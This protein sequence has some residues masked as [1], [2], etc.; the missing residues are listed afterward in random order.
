MSEFSDYS[1]NH[2]LQRKNFFQIF[3]DFLSQN[4]Q[5][6]QKIAPNFSE[7]FKSEK[8][9]KCSFYLG[10]DSR[11]EKNNFVWRAHQ[12]ARIVTKILLFAL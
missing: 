8:K 6:I 2:P 11:K 5:T 9:N 1:D 7:N 12:L 3:S 4:F 10:Y